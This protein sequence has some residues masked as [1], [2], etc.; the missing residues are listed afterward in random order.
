MKTRRQIWR[1]LLRDWLYELGLIVF[2]LICTLVIL[3]LIFS[4]I[5]ALGYFGSRIFV[6][7]LVRNN[8][9]NGL[10][11][12]AANVNHLFGILAVFV[13]LI[14]FAIFK[15]ATSIKRA[16]DREKNS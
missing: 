8:T 4:G 15:V 16:Y 11:N 13:F 6:S 5:Y 9:L 7:G 1:N 12:P 3:A 14:T 10:L 2:V